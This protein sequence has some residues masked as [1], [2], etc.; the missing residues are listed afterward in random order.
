MA[1]KEI[2]KMEIKKQEQRHHQSNTL[3]RKNN[4]MAG[5]ESV[6]MEIK[7]HEQKHHQSNTIN[8]KKGKN[9]TG[10][11]SAKHTETKKEDGDTVAA[12]ED[13]KMES[14][15]SNRDRHHQPNTSNKE[16]TKQWQ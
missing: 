15:I 3:T 10:T 9:N 14:N 12:K 2:V 11:A 4:P 1:V 13:A 8:K 5:K 16:R 6:K 7:T